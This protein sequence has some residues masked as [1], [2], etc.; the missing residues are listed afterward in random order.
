MK[1]ILVELHIAKQAIHTYQKENNCISEDFVR[2]YEHTQH[3]SIIHYFLMNRIPFSKQF[4][5]T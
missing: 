3:L 2:P 4:P 5:F 1:A